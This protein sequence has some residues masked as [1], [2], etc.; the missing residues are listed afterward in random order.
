MALRGDLAYVYIADDLE[1]YKIQPKLEETEI[2][3]Y[4]SEWTMKIQGDDINAVVFQNFYSVKIYYVNPKYKNFKTTYWHKKISYFSDNAISFQP[5]E[6][7]EVNND[8]QK[9]LRTLFEGIKENNPG[10]LILLAI[11]KDPNL[12]KTGNFFTSSL[13][14]IKL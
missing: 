12:F 8:F 2:E 9:G 13:I 5:D 6:D 11:P 3:G 1:Y 10:V 14:F 4:V 7:D